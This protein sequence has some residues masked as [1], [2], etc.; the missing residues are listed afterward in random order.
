M[1][2]A[3]KEYISLLP[4]V[5]DNAELIAEGIL[6]KLNESSLSE[7]EK[8]EIVR[9][10][11][12]CKECPFNS[13][14]ASKIKDLNYKSDRPDAHCIHCG[15]NIELKTHSLASKCG[16]SVYN[17]KNPTKQIPLKWESFNK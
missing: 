9:R 4:R 6:N 7:E 16:I 10:S 1:L 15:C 3:I 8:F 17:T 14:N 2:K 11:L 5:I 12:I 13:E